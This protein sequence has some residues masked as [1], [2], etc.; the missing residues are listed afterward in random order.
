MARHNALTVDAG[1]SINQPVY[2]RQSPTSVLGRPEMLR[3]EFVSDKFLPYL[4]EECQ[5]NPGVY[6]FELAHWLSR[7][8]IK[9]GVITTYPDM[10]DWG[11]LIWKIE[12]DE[13]TMIGCQSDASEDE[14]YQGK[15]IRWG[16]FLDPDQT[17]ARPPYTDAA[18]GK[19][20]HLADTIVA[21]L[22][23]EGI[24]STFADS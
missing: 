13:E 21:V 5:S 3:L 20:R 4:P 2:G 15:A 7:E 24:A 16:I 8:L 17:T 11:W 9:R 19:M 18:R 10:E 22:K 1:R 12:D 23:D 6:G 14:G